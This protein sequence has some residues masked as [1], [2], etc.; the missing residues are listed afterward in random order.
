MS[1]LQ[2]RVDRG[3][4]W[5]DERCPSWRSRID[6][7]TLDIKTGCNCVLGQL[8]LVHQFIFVEQKEY[9]DYGFDT[10]REEANLEFN[11]EEWNR[12]YS[13]LREAWI[14]EINCPT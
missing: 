4:E 9:P 6:I 8:N 7:H 10:T 1:S 11:S 5:L 3:I 13:D 2:E 14:H 12:A